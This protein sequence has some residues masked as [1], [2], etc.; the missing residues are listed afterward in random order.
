LAS[1]DLVSMTSQVT[2]RFYIGMLAFQSGDED[3]VRIHQ[4]VDW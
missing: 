3:K 2:W 4:R 1:A